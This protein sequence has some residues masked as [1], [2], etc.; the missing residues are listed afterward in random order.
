[1]KP[2][3]MKRSTGYQ[4]INQTKDIDFKY[5]LNSQNIPIK[6]FK[7]NI[8]IFTRRSDDEIT[9]LGPYLIAESINYIRIDEEDFID[10]FE[11]EITSSLPI[12]T[13]NQNNDS[14]FK[15]AAAIKEVI[16]HSSL[17]YLKVF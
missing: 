16:S 8:I 9:L 11:I 7:K 10:K 14:C 6:N 4:S 3:L 1:M 5:L 17:R 12:R 2:Y 13:I 15:Q